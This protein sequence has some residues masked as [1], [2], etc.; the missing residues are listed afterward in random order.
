MR[1]E[2]SASESVTMPREVYA[3]RNTQSTVFVPYNQASSQWGASVAWTSQSGMTT[4]RRTWLVYIVPLNRLL[5]SHPT[6]R[7]GPGPRGLT[8]RADGS[9]ARRSCGA[10]G[11]RRRNTVLTTAIPTVRN[12]NQRMTD[13]SSNAR[14]TPPTTA[15]RVKPT[16]RAEYM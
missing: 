6:L 16:L 9:A 7:N 13:R 8:R 14:A 15:P 10:F 1:T 5:S 2:R 11:R 4:F 12:G 3:G